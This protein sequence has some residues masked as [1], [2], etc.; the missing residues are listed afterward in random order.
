MT[1]KIGDRVTWPGRQTTHKGEIVAICKGYAWI[2]AD[3]SSNGL[4]IS[5]PI[6]ILTLIPRLEVTALGVPI[7]T[8]NSRSLCK[9][10]FTGF[11]PT[12]MLKI[13]AGTLH[14]DYENGQFVCRATNGMLETHGILEI[15]NDA[16][17]I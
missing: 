16:S 15:L 9:T 17:L 1:L 11:K 3:D 6:D 14:I 5:F 13:P 12:P 7:G 10:E 8:A 2:E 4:F